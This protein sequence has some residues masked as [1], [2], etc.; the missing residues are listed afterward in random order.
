MPTDFFSALDGAKDVGNFIRN[1][2]LCAARLHATQCDLGR[3]LISAAVWRDIA[4]F[5]DPVVTA[6]GISHFSAA[7]GAYQSDKFVQM[8]GNLM[9]ET[10]LTYLPLSATT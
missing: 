2:F 4:E 3:T 5:C 9:G 6:E 1:A 8:G 10:F 7:R